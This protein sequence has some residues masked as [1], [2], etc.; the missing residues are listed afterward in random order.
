MMRFHYDNPEQERYTRLLLEA[1]PWMRWIGVNPA[2]SKILN[3]LGYDAYAIK[4][5]HHLDAFTPTLPPLVGESALQ[6]STKCHIFQGQSL[7]REVQVIAR[8]PMPIKKA[9]VRWDSDY[10]AYKEIHLGDIFVFWANKERYRPLPMIKAMARGAVVLTPSPGYHMC[11]YYGWQDNHNCLFMRSAENVLETVKILTRNRDL[12]MEIAQ[13]AI[14][15]ASHYS[16]SAVGRELGMCLMMPLR[17]VNNYR[18][19]IR[20]LGFR[21]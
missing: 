14:E 17:E 11:M 2:F 18:Q 9:L 5:L 3:E 7:C 16:Y 20:F 1:I 6:N 8:S 21:F 10:S 13:A 19:K 12:K 4:P 15:T